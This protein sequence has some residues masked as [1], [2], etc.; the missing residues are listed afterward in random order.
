VQIVQIVQMQGLAVIFH[1]VRF[2]SQESLVCG[3]VA[4]LRVHAV[5]HE[6]IQASGS[7]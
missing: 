5:E 4:G 2:S 6:G 3:L 7:A 1:V